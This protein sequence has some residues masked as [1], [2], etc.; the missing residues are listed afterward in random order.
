MAYASFAAFGNGTLFQN[1]LHDLGCSINFLCAITEGSPSSSL[2]SLWL[3]GSKQ[4]EDRTVQ[5]LIETIQ[6][7]KEI[8]EIAKPWPL[9]LHDARLWRTLL[10][11]FRANVGK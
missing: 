2:I 6:T 1:G 10:A 7:L 3:N 11:D 9:D 5:P 8:K 4:L